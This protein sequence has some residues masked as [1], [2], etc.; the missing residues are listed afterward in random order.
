AGAEITGK[1]GHLLVEVDGVRHAR[2]ARKLEVKLS[3]SKG[4]VQASVA[5]SGMVQVEFE[6]GITDEKAIRDMLRKSGLRPCGSG[7]GGAA[8]HAA[9]MDDD[10]QHDHSGIFGSN[11]ELIFAILSGVLLGVGYGLS[12]TGVPN[13][14]SLALYIGAYFFGGFF[15]AKEAIETVAKGGFEIDFLMLVAAIGAAILGEWAEGALL[16]FLFSLG[17]ALEHYAMGRARKSIAAL[18]ELAPKTAMLKRD[19]KTKEIGIDQ[20]SVGDVIVVRPNSKI[21]ADGV[22]V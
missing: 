5:P 20:L 9:Q 1:Y 13:W 12:Y 8:E 18:T 17:H 19:G 7:S 15:T 16:L 11:T 10:H 3:A 6:S 4:V 2:H 21:S 14:V 22:V